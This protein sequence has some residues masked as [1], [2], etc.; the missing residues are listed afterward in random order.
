MTILAL[1]LAKSKSVFCDFN[2]ITG[3]VTFGDVATKR[4]NFR[5]LLERVRPERVVIEICPLAGW[6]HDL[7]RELN[8]EIQV[9]DPTQDAWKW[10]NVKRKT[11]E[12]DALKLARLSALGQL[13]L[14]H[15]PSP[16][17][18]QWRRL[19]ELRHTL[20]AERTRCKNRIRAVLLQE[21][22]HWLPGQRGWSQSQR[23]ELSQLARPLVECDSLELWRGVLFIELQHLEQIETLVADVEAKLDGLAA[24]DARTVLLRTIPG[25][26]QRTA[27]IIV[28]TIDQARRFKTARQVASYAGLTPRRFQSGQMDRQGRISKRGSRLLRQ[29]LNQAAWM[30]VRWNRQLRAV[31][32][33]ISGG[34]TARRK[35]AIVAVMRK[36]LVTA[37]AMLR[38]A[39]A[40]RPPR[41]AS[42]PV[43]A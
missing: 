24:A 6:V 29:V 40:Y 27:E 25:V 41:V 21:E 20:V 10:K 4:A 28:T 11:D 35:L 30:A 32:L 15:I 12:D 5:E 36:L 34:V 13:N 26:A 42:A 7:V 17:M 3:E 8:I 22:H 38:D 16:K 19:V 33:R 18:R 14:V 39:R 1:D 31:Y 43:A 9:A 23:A 2:T 37:W